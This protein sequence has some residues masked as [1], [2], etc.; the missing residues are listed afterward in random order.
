M[1]IN[2]AAVFQ[3]LPAAIDRL[4]REVLLLRAVSAAQKLGEGAR[5]GSTFF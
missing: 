2:N 4:L 5:G 3:C 1:T